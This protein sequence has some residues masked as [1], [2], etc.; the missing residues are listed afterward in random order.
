[1]DYSVALAKEL[2]LSSVE[3]K[4]I[5]NCALLHDAGKIGIDS[6]LLNKP[7]K[8]TQEEWQKMKTHPQAGADLVKNV[9]LLAPCVEPI[10]HHHEWYD[11]SGYPDGLKGD[12]IPMEARLLA[13]TDAFATMTSER[14]YSE[15]M[16]HESALAEIKRCS[17]NQFDPYLVEQF[18]SIFEKQ[19]MNT[20]KK[21]RR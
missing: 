18:A 16:S 2:K 12:A 1:M 3:I 20:K 7:G 21:T 8:L 19:A 6:E 10:L 5:E 4:I 15:T 11:G 14:S 9:P 17:G 13:I